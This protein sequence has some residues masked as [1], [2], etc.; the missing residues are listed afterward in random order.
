VITLEKPTTLDSNMF[1]NVYT[2][3]W[4]TD[5]RTATRWLVALLS[6]TSAHSLCLTRNDSLWASAGDLPSQAVDEIV[7][8]LCQHRLPPEEGDKDNL[9]TARDQKGSSLAITEDLIRYILLD[10]GKIECMLYTSHLRD[11]FEL[12]LVFDPDVPLSEI[13]RQTASLL[14]KL[15]V[16]DASENIQ[17]PN[18]EEMG[19]L[20]LEGDLTGLASKQEQLA[21]DGL[22]KG[23]LSDHNTIARESSGLKEQGLI[24]ESFQYGNPS[25]NIRC[26]IY[27]A[28]IMLPR[29][30]W[31]KIS[32]DL[33]N[34]MPARIK[35]IS[36]AFG[37]RLNRIVIKPDY[38]LWFVFLPE[39][40]SVDQVVGTVKQFS[41]IWIFEEFPKIR[42]ENPSGDFWAPGYLVINAERPI[43][44]TIIDTFIQQ[45]RSRQGVEGS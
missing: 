13:R 17:L 6:T 21:R 18:S 22:E 38:V 34:K 31:H 8:I 37:F 12:A 20:P 26:Q 28:C 42:L 27:I 1:E 33:A 9:D 44:Q 40:L 32:G 16:T 23:Y 41:S 4:V 29:L 35:Q 7:D 15:L 25:H 45:T 2:P 3:S 24:A 11:D 43:Q 14:H 30:P 10:E 39:E 19:T 36:L 5:S